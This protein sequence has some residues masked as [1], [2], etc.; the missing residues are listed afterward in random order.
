ML[1]IKEFLQIFL[2]KLTY[3]S[4]LSIISSKEE[5]KEKFVNVI[6]STTEAFLPLN[7]LV[8]KDKELA[9]LTKEKEFLEKELKIVRGKLSNKG[10][11]DKAPEA[12]VNKEREK[13]KDFMLKLEKVEKSLAEL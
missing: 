3:S 2:V 5:L 4:N 1:K 6:A 13:E 10:F 9:R 8:D 12:L 11:T 7:E